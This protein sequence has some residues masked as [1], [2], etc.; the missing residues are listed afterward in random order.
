MGIFTALRAI[1]IS[2]RLYLLGF[3]IT[4]LTLIP[5]LIF[6]SNYQASLLE[7]KRIKTRH[8]VETASSLLVNFYQQ[9]QQG[10]LTRAQAQQMA[11][12]AIA[13]LRY[14]EKDYFWINDM[15]P[16]MIM[17]P[18][19]P[20]LDGQDLSGFKDP[21]GN[22]LFVA[23]TNTVKNSGA[24]FV[25]YYWEKPGF[26]LPI[27]KISYVKGFRPW[28]WIVGSGVY[29]DDIQAQFYSE[30]KQLGL[31]LLGSLSVM[32]LLAWSIGR[33]ITKPCEQTLS[34]MQDIAEGNGDLTQRLPCKGNDELSRIAQAFNV[35]ASRIGDMMRET[36]PISE[37]I[38]AAA[39]QLNTVATTTAQGAADQHKG[40]DSVAAAMNELHTSNQEVAHSA[41]QAAE[42]AINAHQYSKTG[43]DV[44]ST[45]SSEL[46][47]LLTLL[48][49]TSSSAQELA[50]D[51]Q[52]IGSVLDVI[53][54]IAEQTNLLALNAAIE[55]ARAGEQGRGFAVVADEVRTLATRTQSS[56]NEIE[57]IIGNLQTRANEVSQA[58]T[59][60]REQ[61]TNTA[62]HADDVAQTLSLISNQVTQIRELNQHIAEAS[63]Q[64]TLATEEI[65]IN[66]SQL[67]EHSLNTM[68]QGEHIA[69]ASEQLLASGHSLNTHISHF[70]I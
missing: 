64:Q 2:R 6:A 57:Q 18:F 41:Q 5:L 45:S 17:H 40:V 67:I 37:H 15:T 8:L 20:A 62:K 4:L 51:A 14:E 47:A 1:S 43:I 26:D 11:K 50:N 3:I 61:S 34:A 59:Q 35:F 44:V 42:V 49:N 19:K 30:L 53:R 31:T 54:G 9:E 56:T 25:D 16:T 69:A 28:G 33:S 12:Q 39:L 10:T 29:V 23:M 7:Q 38:S 70:K 24:G 21:H 46:Q 63:S 27:E 32:V 36:A 66:L 68:Q 58:L 65:N 48:D 55:A 52:A 22:A 60:T 13:G